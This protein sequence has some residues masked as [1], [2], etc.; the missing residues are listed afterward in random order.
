MYKMKRLNNVEFI[1]S[2]ITIAGMAGAFALGFLEKRHAEYADTASSGYKASSGYDA[3]FDGG[4]IA[5]GIIAAV[6][7]YGI[8]WI[9]V[10]RFQNRSN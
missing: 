2:L 1:L 10:L 6:A 5:M 9:E 4:A 8:I 3:G 7:L